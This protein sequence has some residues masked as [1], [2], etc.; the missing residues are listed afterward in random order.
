MKAEDIA[1]RLSP[2]APEALAAAAQ[3]L[4]LEAIVNVLDALEGHEFSSR[5]IEAL[6]N[7]Q[8]AQLFVRVN[9]AAVVAVTPLAQRL[10][11]EIVEATQGDWQNALF[12]VGLV[13]RGVRAGCEMAVGKEESDGCVRRAQQMLA[14]TQVT[15]APKPQGDA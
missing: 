1:A 2:L 7:D 13:G 14:H 6:S 3:A 12:A 10:V 11:H 15:V 8:R 5:L 9:K 4:P